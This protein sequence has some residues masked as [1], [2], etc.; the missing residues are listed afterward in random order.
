MDDD[1]SPPDVS[2]LHT[3]VNDTSQNNL[4]NIFFQL[5][6][7][8]LM[9]VV[10]IIV[11]Y[12]LVRYYFNDVSWFNEGWSS[13]EGATRSRTNT[14]SSIEMSNS[15]NSSNNHGS[16]NNSA[17]ST[18]SISDS[19]LNDEDIKNAEKKSLIEINETEEANSNSSGSSVNDIESANNNRSN[20]NNNNKR[21]WLSSLTSQSFNVNQW[22]EPE[23]TKQEVVQS[24][25]FC[26]TGFML[27]FAVQGL[28][29]E[30]MLTQPYDGMYFTYS[31]GL[32]FVNRIGG[33]LL[34]LFLIYYFQVPM[35]P[36]PLWE[37]SFPAV[38]NMLSS[39]CQYEALQYV[40]FPTQMLFKAFKIVPTMLMGKFLHDKTYE[41]YEY[42]VAC[43]IGFGIF[44]FIGSSDEI[45][46]TQNVLGS[47][48][49][50]TGAWCGIVLLL[51]FL[52]FDSFTGPW[53][54]EMF[55]QHPGMSSLQM[56]L[57]MNAFSSAFSFITLVHQNELEISL[58][59]MT[60]H[61][62]MLAHTVVFFI[63]ATV[64]QAF[65]YLTVQKFGAVILSI[66]MA[67]RILL[68]L[69]LSCVVYSHP[70]SELGYVG[71]FIVFGAV[72]YRVY[73]KNEGGALIRWRADNSIKRSV[74]SEWHEHIDC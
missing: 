23:G 24:L 50:V 47:P 9:Y 54:T 26:T 44:V 5:S 27:S 33:F 15:N 53:Q 59:F 7:N 29:Q 60:D 19:L 28:V 49:G 73:R 14:S 70:V 18:S 69:I 35:V 61:P 8:F 39:W 3:N 57:I 32:I 58:T 10:L 36:S 56:M 64:G 34:S 4:G 22:G 21:S 16:R 20:N 41:Y 68:S 17:E 43:T 1:P 25:I 11:F 63:C 74:Y 51:L 40:T 12:M 66:I 46:F 2:I 45:D 55:G 67:L 38:A 31:Y 6:I 48:D 52:S 13:K 42:T 72:T 30:R 37:Y 71:I 62:L 65:I